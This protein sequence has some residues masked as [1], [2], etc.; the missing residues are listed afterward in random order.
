MHLMCLRLFYNA[1]GELYMCWA[2]FICS[3]ISQEEFS[4]RLMGA[5][6]SDWVTCRD[7]WAH[8]NRQ[9]QWMISISK[10]SPTFPFYFPPINSIFTIQWTLADSISSCILSSAEI[11][12]PASWRQENGYNFSHQVMGRQDQYS[13]CWLSF[14]NL[15]NIGSNRSLSHNCL[16]FQIK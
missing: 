6:H 12:W 1:L 3:Y 7:K 5:I 14:C 2:H 15:Y 13:H 11:D 8:G 10:Q 9:R 4:V 16:H